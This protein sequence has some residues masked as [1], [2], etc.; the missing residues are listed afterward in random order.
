MRYL[1]IAVALA[2]WL[3]L[4]GCSPSDAGD[5]APAQTPP[6][7]PAIP[8]PADPPSALFVLGD[9]LSDV[10]NL[11]A[12]ADNLLSLA[13]DPP[14]VGLCNPVDVLV[15]LRPCDNLFYRQSRVSDG[16]VAVEYLA[17]HFGLAELA[18]S[19]HFIPGRPV[20]GTG[21][22]VA[23]AKARGQDEE[24]LSPQVDMLL[25]DNASLLPADAVYVIIIGGNDAIDALQ[26]A[27]AGTQN[28]PQMSAAIVTAAVDAIGA[29]VVR[30]LDF[31]ARQLIV[32][33]VPD[34]AA[35]PAVRADARASPDEAAILA[36]GSAVSDSFNSEL[37]AL[38]DGI[39]GSGQ[40]ASPTPLAL[41]RFD[42]HAALRAAQDT[43]AAAG[44]NIQNACFDSTTYLQSPTAER[45]FHTD[46]APVGGA[47]PR[48]AD[49]VF[50]DDIHPTGAVHAA[51]GTAL[52]AAVP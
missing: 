5:D 30:L 28:A 35:L 36:A 22:A 52:I 50:W 12:A 33:N 17:A 14:S 19:L 38:L 45:I 13:F 23:S 24:D 41:A 42:L 47:M 2:F 48:F 32:A 9:S 1:N 7:P 31:G 43:V 11:A 20:V 34:L 3:M 26:A 10:G 18:P 39:E 6:P 27:V 21:Y 51:V 25:L 8:P 44:G 46:C 49:F 16:P 37:T 4:E 29:S 15:L 40:W